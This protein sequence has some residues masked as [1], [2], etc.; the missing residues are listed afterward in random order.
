MN[1]LE[2]SFIMF[3]RLFAYIDPGTG[4]LI[5][6]ILLGGVA[7]AWMILKLFGHRILAMFGL[8]KKEKEEEQH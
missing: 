5:L 2:L 6:Q 8:S 1:L 3:S 4:S 7:G